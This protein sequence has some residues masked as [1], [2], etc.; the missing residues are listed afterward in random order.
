VPLRPGEI[1]Q[2]KARAHP[3]GAVRPQCKRECAGLR[4]ARHE[5][6][7]GRWLRKAQNGDIGSW[8]AAGELGRGLRAAWHHELELVPFGQGL[9]GG[10]HYVRPPDDRA[11]MPLAG[12][13]DRRSRP[14]Q[15]RGPRG[16]LRGKLF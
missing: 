4:F 2:A 11:E 3:A 5:H 12:P 13:A 7:R 6:G 8:V 14:L 15:R 1:D 16:K 10:D 9:L